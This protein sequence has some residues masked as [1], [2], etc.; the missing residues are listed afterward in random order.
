MHFILLGLNLAHQSNLVIMKITSIKTSLVLCLLSISILTHVRAQDGDID[1]ADILKSPQAD[2][3][4]YLDN[5]IGV[6]MLSFANGMAGGWYNT[7]KPHKP[8]GFDITASINVANVPQSE[9]LFTFNQSEYDVLTLTR[10]TNELP[11]LVGGG[12]SDDLRNLLTL[13]IGASFVAPDGNTYSYTR[14]YTFDAPTG[15]DVE[16]FPIAGVP[17]PTIQLGIGLVKNTDLKVR[18]AAYSN[19]DLDFDLLGFGLLHDVKQWIPGIKQVPID[20]SIFFGTTKLK[21]EQIIERTDADFLADGVATFESRA[22]TYQVLISKKLSFFTPYFGI[23]VNSVSSSIKI[24]GDYTLLE[25]RDSN[26]DPYTFSDPVDLLFEGGGSIRSTIGFRLKLA[27]ITLHTDYTIQNYNMLT[28][29]LGLS[30]R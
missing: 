24:D 4:K 14:D 11:T 30:V 25:V 1:F 9:R 13:P 17:V 5:Y 18:Y 16:D 15:Q 23:G 10:A 19:S 7:A 26:N 29:G 12:N 2:M 6:G 20:I 8:L 28:V 27:I 21:A 22:T 3:E